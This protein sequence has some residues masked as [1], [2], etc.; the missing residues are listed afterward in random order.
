MNDR[1]Y[2]RVAGANAFDEVDGSLGIGRSFH[3]HAQK[4]IEAGG[5]FHDG[6]EQTLAKF[7]V[8]IEAE[9][10]ELAGNIGVQAF[11]RDAFKNF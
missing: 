2:G 9:L 1:A 8:D 11:L 3:V 6:A 5:A 4:I 10:R 7:D